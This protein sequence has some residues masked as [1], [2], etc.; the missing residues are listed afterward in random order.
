MAFKHPMWIPIAWI[1]CLANI[2][3]LWWAFR[4]GEPWHAF[5]HAQL[6]LLF[7]VGAQALLARPRI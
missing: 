2:A 4:Q 1:L 7:G 5:V 3:G 6:A